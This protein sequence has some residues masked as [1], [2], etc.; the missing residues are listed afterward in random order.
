VK[1]SQFMSLEGLEIVVTEWDCGC[2]HEEGYTSYGVL[3]HLR[4]QSC[5]DC[6][7]SLAYYLDNLGVDKRAQLTLELPSP[8]GD[9]RP[10]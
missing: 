1:T 5:S 7:D 10:V 9:R 8:E 6:F 2:W 4:F 3:E